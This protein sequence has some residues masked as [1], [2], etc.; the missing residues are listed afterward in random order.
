MAD[1]V[2]S[3]L[4]WPTPD[5]AIVCDTSGSMHDVLLARAFTEVEGILARAGLRQGFV[6]V[7]AVDTNVHAVR[8]EIRS[9]DVALAG[10]G[11]T[12][13]GEGMR[14]AAALRPRP[15]I[16][17]V[18]TGG[19]TPWPSERPKNTKVLVVLLEQAGWP[20]APTPPEWVR[21]ISVSG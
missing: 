10:G 9:S 20:S 1:V 19:F 15:S 13:M 4:H 2:L 3:T 6:R 11:G 18:P 12:D 8:R 5:I 16:V 17:I 21:A 14:A 7:L